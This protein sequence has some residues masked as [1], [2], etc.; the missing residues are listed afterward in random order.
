MLSANKE[1]RLFSRMQVNATVILATTSE[2][3]QGTCVNLSP[4][5]VLM[6]VDRGYCEPGQEWQLVLPS[7]SEQVP[8]LMAVARVLRVEQEDT[9]DLVALYLED[10][11]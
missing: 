4:E 5:G 8:P 1:Q 3:I 9:C 11:H 6:R 2:R 7:A 10:V